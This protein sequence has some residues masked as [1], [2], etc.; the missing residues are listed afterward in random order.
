M[1]PGPPQALYF[2]G[3][4]VASVPSQV[5]LFHVFLREKRSAAVAEAKRS[6]RRTRREIEVTRCER[7]SEGV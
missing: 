5:G 7:V 3:A 2:N 1:P 6:A 4:L